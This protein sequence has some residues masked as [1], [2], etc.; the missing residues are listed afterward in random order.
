MYATVLLENRIREFT[1][2]VSIDPED[3]LWCQSQLK[4]TKSATIGSPLHHTLY[5]L[6]LSLC[7]SCLTRIANIDSS[8]SKSSG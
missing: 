3:N 5:E 7:C 1:T 8:F 2:G 4:F 6:I